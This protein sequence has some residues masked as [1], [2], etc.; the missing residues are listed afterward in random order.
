M[1]EFPELSRVSR[2]A[3]VRYFLVSASVYIFILVAMYILVDWLHVD[4]V[5]S[6]LLVYA[7]AYVAEYLTTLIFVFRREHAWNKLVKFFVN[8][9]AFLA[10]GATLFKWLT[11]NQFDYLSATLGVAVIL[12]PFRFLSNKYFVYR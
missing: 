5:A 8:V 10:I 2:W 3:I 11:S 7:S 4:Q 6:Y 12:L 1:M 9:L